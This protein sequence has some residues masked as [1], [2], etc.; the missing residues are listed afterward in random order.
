M[1]SETRICDF[2]NCNR[3]FAYFTA[4]IL[5]AYKNKY[6]SAMYNMISFVVIFLVGITVF[7]QILLIL[8]G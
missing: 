3:F 8:T 5:Y 6:N 2:C 7:V 4:I 1:A